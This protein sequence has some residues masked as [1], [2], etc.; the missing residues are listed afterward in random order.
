[1]AI[2]RE[3]SSDCWENDVLNCPRKFWFKNNW[4]VKLSEEFQSDLTVIDDKLNCVIEL[5]RSRISM[6]KWRSSPDGNRTWNCD[7][8]EY[9][10]N[11]RRFF[12]QTKI[13]ENKQRNFFEKFSFY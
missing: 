6:N 8:D 5:K 10:M 13:N 3:S 9:D 4:E 2:R 11:N 7:T 12:V 1:M